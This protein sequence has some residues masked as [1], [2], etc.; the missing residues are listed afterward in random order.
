[1]GYCLLESVVAN[2]EWDL[3]LTAMLFWAASTEPS[4]LSTPSTHGWRIGSWVRPSAFL[5]ESAWK[6]SE[7]VPF[8][9][10]KPLCCLLHSPPLTL[11][12]GQNKACKKPRLPRLSV[13]LD[14]PPPLCMPWPS[15]R[16]TWREFV[17]TFYF[18]SLYYFS[19]LLSVLI[20]VF[21]RL[22]HE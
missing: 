22:L 14:R 2:A 3:E 8:D 6:V 13:P 15:C 9:S 16:C 7:V 1:M 5:P 21:S 18:L 11:M 12:A 10:P 19:K 20:V 17:L 4:T